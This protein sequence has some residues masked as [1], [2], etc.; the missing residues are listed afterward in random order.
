MREEFDYV[1][2]DTPPVEMVSDPLILATQSDGVLLVVD[3]RNTRKAAVRRS[4]RNLRGV[5]AAILGTVMNNTETSRRGYYG[6]RY[7]SYTYGG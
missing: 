4:M 5:D 3:A 6:G 2:L 1:L 7:K